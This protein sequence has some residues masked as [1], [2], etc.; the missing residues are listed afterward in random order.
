MH[1]L[2]GYEPKVRPTPIRLAKTRR[3]I[4]RIIPCIHRKRIQ[5]GD[6][7][8]IRLWMSLFSIYRVLKYPGMVKL[9]TITGDSPFSSLEDRQRNSLVS[10]FGN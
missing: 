10:L 2:A 3:G 9:E 7:R 5:L 6:E 1:A 8:V 4:P